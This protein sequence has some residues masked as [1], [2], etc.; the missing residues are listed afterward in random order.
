MSLVDA[1]PS[2]YDSAAPIIKMKRNLST[3]YL[4]FPIVLVN[5][6]LTNVPQSEAEKHWYVGVCSRAALGALRSLLRE[7][8][9]FLNLPRG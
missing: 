3:L 4:A 7:L 8:P 2:Q 6:T 1:S 5:G 9:G